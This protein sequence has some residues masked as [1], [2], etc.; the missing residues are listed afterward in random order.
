VISCETDFENQRAG[1]IVLRN[2]GIRQ[3]TVGVLTK[4]DRIEPGSGPAHKWLRLL[5]GRE[6]VLPQGWFCVKQPDLEQLQRGITWE[7][8]RLGEQEFFA[9]TSPWDALEGPH[10]NRLGRDALAEHLGTILSRLVS[11]ELPAIRKKVLAELDD[12]NTKLLE[13]TPPHHDNPQ[14][15]VITLLRDFNKKVSKHIEGIPPRITKAMTAIP[16]TASGLLHELHG[17]YDRF[18]DKVHKTTPDL[19]PWDSGLNPNQNLEK[20]MLDDLAKDD[21][22]VRVT[23]G[24]QFFVDEVMELAKD[25][26]TRELPGNYPFSVKQS[27]IAESTGLWNDLAIDCFDEVKTIIDAHLGNLIDEHF[28]NYNHG[29]LKAAVSRATKKVLVKLAIETARKID[30]LCASEGAPYTQSEEAFL[31]YRARLLQRYIM[32]NNQSLGKT[33]VVQ[34]LQQFN[35]SNYNNMN[36]THWNYINTAISQLQALGISPLTAQDFIKLL[37]TSDVNPGLEIMAEVRAYFE[38][39]Y[40]RFTDNVPKQIDTDFIRET[41]RELDLAMRWELDLSE[42]SCR[43][44]LQE[45]E[46]IIRRREEYDGKKFQ[47]ESAKQRLAEYYRDQQSVNSFAYSAWDADFEA[48]NAEP[49]LQP[50][51]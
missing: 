43:R 24:P 30:G 3:R 6:N 4:V 31:D 46:E 15:E 14:R 45:P 21:N 44:Y 26:R 48:A 42:R 5:Q 36:S 27:L 23:K 38:V 13:L 17:A 7:E 40:K 18:R 39:A 34:I 49:E 19:R 51:I 29:G 16:A 33:N 25:S 10:R 20:Q 9:M 1:H 22:A 8:A 11:R 28:D 41:D 2:P 32:V 37:H 47:L 12:V 50:V 35:P